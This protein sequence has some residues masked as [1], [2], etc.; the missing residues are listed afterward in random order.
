LQLSTGTY[1]GIFYL[2]TVFHFLHVVVG[3]GLLVWLLAPAL[4]RDPVAPRRVPRSEPYR[5]QG[6]QHGD[7]PRLVF[8]RS[9]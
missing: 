6:G 4:R 9:G 8:R 2:M 5:P 3:L 1:G 7:G